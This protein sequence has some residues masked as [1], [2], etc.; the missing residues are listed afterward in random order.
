MLAVSPHDGDV[1]VLELAKPPQACINSV[2]L[3]AADK[4]PG[5][6]ALMAEL[7]VN[8]NFEFHHLRLKTN[9]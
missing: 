1:G 4:A 9:V 6:L 8:D 3:E 7:G 2:P 5:K